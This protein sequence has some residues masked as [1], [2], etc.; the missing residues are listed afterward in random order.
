MPCDGKCTALVDNVVLFLLMS[1]DRLLSLDRPQPG[2]TM[3]FC[4]LDVFDFPP[5]VLAFHLSYRYY[6]DRAEPNRRTPLH[7]ASFRGRRR[8]Q[9]H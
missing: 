7:G 3:R 6:S 4:P 9:E 8:K 2:L 1:L 5:F